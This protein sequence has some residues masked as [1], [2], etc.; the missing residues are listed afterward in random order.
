M[1][2]KSK[3]SLLLLVALIALAVGFYM[4]WKQRQA[5]SGKSSEKSAVSPNSLDALAKALFG[6][7]AKRQQV[8]SG[9]N[10]SSSSVAAQIDLGAVVQLIGDGVKALGKGV[11]YVAKGIGAGV[12]ALFGYS[13]ATEG[14]GEAVSS[15]AAVAARNGEM[16]GRTATAASNSDTYTIDDSFNAATGVDWERFA[17]PTI[18]TGDLYDASGSSDSIPST[19]DYEAPAGFETDSSP[20]AGQV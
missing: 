3:K 7:N 19:L 12:A 5:Q 9:G 17:F 1:N 20:Y 13:S 18:G 11:A 15:K 10:S 8:Q 4:W 6:G 2:P 14:K 16:V